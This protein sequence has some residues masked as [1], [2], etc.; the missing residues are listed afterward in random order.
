MPAD[1]WNL[2]VLL[3]DMVEGKELFRHIH[4]QK[5]RYDAKLHVAEMIALIGSPPPGVI[6]R[7]QYMR[8]CSWPKPVR[9]EDGRVSQTAE[10]YFCGPFFDNNDSR[11]I[12]DHIPDRKLGDTASFLEE[13]EREAFLDFAKA[14]L[15][16][17]PDARKTAGE[18]IV[19]PFLQS[20][21]TSA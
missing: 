2:G 11:N 17:H 5:G 21:Q 13:E 6:Q 1:I 9:Q 15:V 7:Y 19:H 4:D 8:E 3:S 16:W 14:M 12:E 18:L 20:R 10:E